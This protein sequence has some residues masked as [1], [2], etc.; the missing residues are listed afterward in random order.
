[1]IL[2]L[3][4]DDAPE[5]AH[6][7]GKLYIDGVYFGETLEDKD[8]YLESGGVKV[9]GDTA[10]PRGVYGVVL[11]QSQRFGRVMPEVLEVPQ[12]TGVRIHGGNVEK[13]TL[14]CPLLGVVRTA[15]GVANCKGINERLRDRIGEAIADGDE[16]TLEV[17]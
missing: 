14:G 10:I 13:D 8:R 12:F 15:T 16:V 7:W 9:H 4:R 17:K 3:I 2:E 6:N 11:S 5:Q 1:V